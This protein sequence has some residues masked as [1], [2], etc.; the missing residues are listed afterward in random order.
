LVAIGDAKNFKKK[1]HKV[2]DKG[3]S[4]CYYINRSINIS[5]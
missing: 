1:L 5:L 3:F 2:V 4:F